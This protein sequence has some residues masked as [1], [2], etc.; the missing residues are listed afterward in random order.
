VQ[1]SIL[2]FLRWEVLEKEAQM[3]DDDGE[4]GAGEFNRGHDEISIENLDIILL[5]FWKVHDVEGILE[6]IRSFLQDA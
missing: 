6:I 4:D 3:T 1:G 5:W 2:A